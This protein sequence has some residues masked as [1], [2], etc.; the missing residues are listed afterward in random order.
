M[1]RGNRH[2]TVSQG[3]TITEADLVAWSGLVH[4]FTPLH[5]D[6]E[7]AETLMFGQRIA[8]GSIALNLSVGLLFPGNAD[9]LAGR[10]S[11]GWRSIRFTK[12]VL[13][14]DTLT[15]FREIDTA[16]EDENGRFVETERVE[17]RNQHGELV[18]TGYELFAGE[19]QS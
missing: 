16:A 2:R 9:W 19:E 5:S 15:C 17:V 18:M 4:D 1:Q 14:G 6:A 12:P 8:H 11:R 13:I 7:L 10:V 3:R